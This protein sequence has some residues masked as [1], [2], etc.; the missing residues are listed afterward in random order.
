MFLLLMPCFRMSMCIVLMTPVTRYWTSEFLG[1]YV[2]W[3]RENIA[4]QR[5]EALPSRLQMKR[6]PN[7]ILSPKLPEAHD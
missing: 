5:P 7:L 3:E 4:K 1:V 6:K 2:V